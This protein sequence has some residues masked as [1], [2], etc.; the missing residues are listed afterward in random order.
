MNGDEKKY[1]RKHA[2]DIF[3]YHATTR[4]GK[5]IKG[6][7]VNYLSESFD[8]RLSSKEPFRLLIK[9]RTKKK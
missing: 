6:D 3:G 4:D 1:A 8:E 2:A 9:M 7:K 5:K